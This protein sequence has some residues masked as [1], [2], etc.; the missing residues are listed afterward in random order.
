[1]SNFG[2]VP[3]LIAEVLTD[4]ASATL[5]LSSTSPVQ[6]DVRRIVQT[7]RDDS[8]YG[9]SAVALP[10]GWTQI[11][12]AQSLGLYEHTRPWLGLKHQRAYVACGDKA[13]RSILLNDE[14][15]QSALFCKACTGLMKD[16]FAPLTPEERSFQLVQASL[17]AALQLKWKAPNGDPV[18][19][20]CTRLM[21][22]A[23]VSTNNSLHFAQNIQLEGDAAHQGALACVPCM[24]KLAKV[25]IGN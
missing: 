3:A 2:P 4:F 8:L 11:P 7:P 6:G 5:G 15:G 21:P 22:S 16:N 12:I 10:A 18:Y 24:A 20:L 19:M 1:M 25:P 9:A 17:K 14:N 23:N 13:K